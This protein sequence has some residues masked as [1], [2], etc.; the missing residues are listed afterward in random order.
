METNA[1]INRKAFLFK[2]LFGQTLDE[3]D[4]YEY[5]DFFISL[6]PLEGS[7]LGAFYDKTVTY[8]IMP[9][10]DAIIDYDIFRVTGSGYEDNNLSGMSYE[11]MGETDI[12]EID[13]IFDKGIYL[14]NILKKIVTYFQKNLLFKESI[15]L[16]DFIILPTFQIYSKY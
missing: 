4:F 3:M 12:E 13:E 5:E 11:H 1:I 6:M 2:S 7:K 14:K 9:I 16:M 8:F 15:I 10:N